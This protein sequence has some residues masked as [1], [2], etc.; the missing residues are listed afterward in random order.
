[1]HLYKLIT[2]RQLTFASMGLCA[3]YKR[4]EEM[5]KKTHLTL[6]LENIFNIATEN[7]FKVTVKQSMAL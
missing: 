3:V 1:M 4:R 7:A 2:G 6:R 5:R